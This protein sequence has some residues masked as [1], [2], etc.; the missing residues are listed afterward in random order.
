ML[1]KNEISMTKNYENKLWAEIRIYL[2][3]RVVA[4]GRRLWGHMSEKK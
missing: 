2:V 3:T 4:P 1:A